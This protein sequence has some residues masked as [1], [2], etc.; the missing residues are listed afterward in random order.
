V[1]DKREFSRNMSHP[2]VTPVVATVDDSRYTDE[3]DRPWELPGGVRRDCT[4]H[5]SNLLILLGS[6]ALVFG[7]LSCVLLPALVAI[8]LGLACWVLVERDLA[9][10]RKGQMDPGGRRAT[11]EAGALARAALLSG[12]GLCALW[13]FLTCLFWVS[14]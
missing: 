2:P 10:M 14:R 5:R 9:R 4:P 13:A 8:P 7:V 3:E 12:L 1:T 6:V 11:E